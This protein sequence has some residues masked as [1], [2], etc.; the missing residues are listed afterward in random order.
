HIRDK[1]EVAWADANG[2]KIKLSDGVHYLIPTK[3][4]D[5]LRTAAACERA[6]LEVVAT[7]PADALVELTLRNPLARPIELKLNSEPPVAF[8]PRQGRTLDAQFT[9]TRAPDPKPIEFRVNATGIGSFK[10]TAM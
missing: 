6:P 10:Q 2:L 4:N 3:P 5:L 9:I 8:S 1:S 7:G